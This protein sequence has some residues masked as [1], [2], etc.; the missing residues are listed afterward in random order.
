MDSEAMFEDEIE[1]NIRLDLGFLPQ[2]GCCGAEDMRFRGLYAN[3]RRQHQRSFACP[4]PRIAALMVAIDLMRLE[5]PDFEFEAN[6]EY[7]DPLE[8]H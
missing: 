7:F 2:A 3:A 4:P 1:Q 5:F 8:S 6:L